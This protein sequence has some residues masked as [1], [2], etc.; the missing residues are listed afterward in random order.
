M[1]AA[2]SSLLPSKA[3]GPT[4]DGH[5]CRRIFEQVTMKHPVFCYS[6][7]TVNQQLTCRKHKSSQTYKIKIPVY[8]IHS[9]NADYVLG[10]CKRQTANCPTEFPSFVQD[11]GTILSPVLP[12]PFLT[13]HSLMSF[14]HASTDRNCHLSHQYFSRY[15]SGKFFLLSV[16]YSAP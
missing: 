10:H 3:L 6:L 16:L 2:P 14:S 8:I 7:V 15:I 1:I 5:A 4:Q 9:L 12:V 11:Q 13:D